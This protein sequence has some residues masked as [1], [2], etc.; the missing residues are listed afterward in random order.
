[1]I[2]NEC[3]R[4]NIF[5]CSNPENNG[6]CAASKRDGPKAVGDGDPGGNANP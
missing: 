2:Y 4:K 1:M 5:H 3:L 6:K